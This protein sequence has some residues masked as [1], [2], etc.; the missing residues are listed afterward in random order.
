MVMKEHYRAVESDSHS[1]FG[2]KRERLH[3]SSFLLL[4]Q[5]QT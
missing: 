3:F 5:E 1:S 4:E 2:A